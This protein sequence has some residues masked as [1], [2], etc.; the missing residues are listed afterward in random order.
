M[1]N[2][3]FASP[4]PNGMGLGVAMSK[5]TAVI[6][7]GPSPAIGY[8]LVGLKRSLACKAGG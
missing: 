6:Q 1:G 2:P 5:M 7:V 8:K 4:T 3:N